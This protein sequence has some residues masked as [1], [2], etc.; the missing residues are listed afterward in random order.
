MT[1]S[2]ELIKKA[3]IQKIAEKGAAIYQKV[4]VQFEPKENGKFLAID[5]DSE[6]TYLGN[7]SAEALELARKNHPDKV[8]YVVKIGF[9]SA[10]TLARSFGL[11]GN[12]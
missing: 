4:K 8:F 11:S 7:T 12:A 5:I 6:N 10:E 3:D 9:E 1:D 2:Q